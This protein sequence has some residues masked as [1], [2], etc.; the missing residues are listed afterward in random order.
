MLRHSTPDSVQPGSVPASQASMIGGPMRP[1]PINAKVG[2]RGLPFQ[3]EI[4]ARHGNAGQAVVRGHDIDVGRMNH[5]STTQR[6]PAAFALPDAASAGQ[7]ESG[8]LG[9]REQAALGRRPR[10]HLVAAQ[11]ADRERSRMRG[12]RRARRVEALLEDREARHAAGDQTR[13]EFTQ[14]GVRTAQ[15]EPRAAIDPVLIELIDR[16]PTRSPE[17]DAVP[18]G[19]SGSASRRANA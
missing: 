6:Q 4:A 12:R 3:I 9:H 8:R 16:Q 1:L 17:I 11:E 18:I 5:V 10:Q 13:R 14:Q 15:V 7:R 2:I 19:G